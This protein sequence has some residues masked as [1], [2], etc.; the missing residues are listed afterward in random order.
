MVDACTSARHPPLLRPLRR[1]QG[2][3]GLRG[4]VPRRLPARLRRRLVAASGPDRHRQEGVQPRPRRGPLRQE[5]PRG[6]P[7][8]PRRAHDRRQDAGRRHLEAVPGHGHAWPRCS[9]T[10]TPTS[11]RPTASRPRRPREHAGADLR[12]GRLRGPR[13]GRAGRR[14]RRASRS[15]PSGS[16]PPR[17]SRSTSSRTSSVSCATP[18]SCAATAAPRAAFASPGR[19]TG[20]RWP[21]SSAPSRARWPACAAGRRRRPPTG[22]L[23]DAAPGVDRRAGQ[24]APRRR[25][26]DARRRRRG[27]AAGHRGAHE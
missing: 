8:R 9:P 16:P 18:A 11:P 2:H 21:T 15:R 7:R 3:R 1:H 23:T 26:G 6:H 14:G 4:P 13:R 22:R 5:G 20:S 27:R 19:P 24:P 17:R 10:R 12:Q 25:A